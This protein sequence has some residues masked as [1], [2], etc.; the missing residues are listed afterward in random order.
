MN[1]TEL[2]VDETSKVYAFH[3]HNSFIIRIDLSELSCVNRV[4]DVVGS[5]LSKSNRCNCVLIARHVTDSIMNAPNIGDMSN[6]MMCIVKHTKTIEE[7][8]SNVIIQGTVV[9]EAACAAL[10]VFASLAKP[11][12]EIFLTA[13]DDETEKR[14]KTDH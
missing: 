14:I 6:I 3:K 4:F 10:H 13:S 12:F 7:H 11:K 1:A 8:I 2:H 9:D 5:F